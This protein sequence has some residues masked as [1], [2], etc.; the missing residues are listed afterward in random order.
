MKK[1]K[2]IDWDIVFNWKVWQ[3]C[4]WVFGVLIITALVYLIHQTITG[5]IQWTK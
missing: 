5:G 3:Y 1:W 2:L 4:K